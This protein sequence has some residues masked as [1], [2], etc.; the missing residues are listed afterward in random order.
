MRYSDLVASSVSTNMSL[1]RKARSLRPLFAF[2]RTPSFTSI[3]G[4]MYLVGAVRSRRL[5]KLLEP[6]LFEST[7]IV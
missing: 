3:L 4:P 6:A 5:G 2:K 1:H 7:C